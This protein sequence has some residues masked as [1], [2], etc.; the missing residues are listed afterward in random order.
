[1]GYLGVIISVLIWGVSAQAETQKPVFIFDE[2]ESEPRVVVATPT[3]QN[4]V[5]YYTC[6]KSEFEKNPKIALENTQHFIKSCKL[7]LE[8][9]TESDV[10]AF[11]ES[12][13]ELA[14]DSKNYKIYG[15]LLSG[16]ALFKSTYGLKIT[17]KW[18][19]KIFAKIKT[20]KPNLFSKNFEK[21]RLIT[22]RVV[23]GGIVTFSAL[24]LGYVY[25][26]FKNQ[27][28]ADEA[29]YLLTIQSSAG[30]EHMNLSRF[31]RAMQNLGYESWGSV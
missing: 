26:L 1:M 7:A 3:P 24:G 11:F 28:A 13:S 17:G 27:S 18:I 15:V 23:W 25:E 22:K 20:K 16:Y 21:I 2:N 6:L 19:D 29:V 31:F 5:I 9:Q 14:N 8:L 12:I 30:D 10:E 4:G